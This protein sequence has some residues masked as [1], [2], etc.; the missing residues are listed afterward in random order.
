[1]ETVLETGGHCRQEFAKVQAVASEN[2]LIHVVCI[3]K[4]GWCLHRQAMMC[5][6]QGGRRAGY[7]KDYRKSCRNSSM[8][9]KNLPSL[10]SAARS[11]LNTAV[12]SDN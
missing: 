7:D 12:R 2:G 3:C 5:N 10:N 11:C 9:A 1:L 4:S 8:H 6:A